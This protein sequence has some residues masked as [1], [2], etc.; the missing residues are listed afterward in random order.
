M[1]MIICMGIREAPM[2]FEVEHK[3]VNLPI[4]A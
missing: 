4:M 2:L 3:V 1:E